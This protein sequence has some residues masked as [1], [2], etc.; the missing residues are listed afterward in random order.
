[1]LADCSPIVVQLLTEYYTIIVLL[2]NYCCP[3]VVLCTIILQL[4]SDCY[5]RSVQL[6]NYCWPIFL[7]L[8]YNYCPNIT[9]LL[10]YCKTIVVR[11]LYDCCAI[12]VRLFYN[13]CPI[14]IQ[15]LYYATIVQ[16]LHNY[17][18]IVQPS[19]SDCFTTI[20]KFSQN[21]SIIVQLLHDCKKWNLRISSTSRKLIPLDSVRTK[22]LVIFR[23]VPRIRKR[24]PYA[25]RNAKANVTRQEQ[26]I[27]RTV[28]VGP[29]WT[30]SDELLA[31]DS[32]L[33]KKQSDT[34][35]YA[36]SWRGEVLNYN[37]Q[38]KM[39]LSYTGS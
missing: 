20:V 10:Y 5:T 39:Y 38:N 16:L 17:C 33:R 36:L 13:Y 29:L 3:I 34:R 23:Y 26:E 18:T 11:L 32:S 24:L 28:A 27:A 14:V 19:L 6:Y 7:R 4:L 30:L 31:H 22:R 21:Y 15:E 2:Y 1:M 25:K 9:Q 8:F 37:G 35:N 12:V